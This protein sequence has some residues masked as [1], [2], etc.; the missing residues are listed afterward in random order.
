MVIN[1]IGRR[2][3]EREK[4]SPVFLQGMIWWFR[5]QKNKKNWRTKRNEYFSFI[6]PYTEEKGVIPSFLSSN[7]ASRLRGMMTWGSS[8]SVG[9]FTASITPSILSNFFTTRVATSP[10]MLGWIGSRAGAWGDRDRSFFTCGWTKRID[11][12]IDPGTWLV[13]IVFCRKLFGG[14]WSF[15]GTRRTVINWGRRRVDHT[16][17][18]TRGGRFG[19]MRARV[20]VHQGFFFLAVSLQIRFDS[21]SDSLQID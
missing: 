21:I 16:F 10:L 4:Y 14:R 15:R 8:K 11:G 9:T 18:G 5:A 2:H 7:D 3:K 13:E 6:R 19:C 12:W 17:T 1:R 20:G